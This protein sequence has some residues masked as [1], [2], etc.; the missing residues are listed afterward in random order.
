MRR[1]RGDEHGFGHALRA[2]ATHVAGNLPTAGGMSDEDDVGEVKVVDEFGEVVA[3]LVHVMT[4]PG[5]AGPAV[6]PAV[7][8]DHPITVTGQEEHLRVPVVGAE[9]GAVGEDNRLAG[10]PV[11]VEDFRAVLDGNL[12]GKNS[13]WSAID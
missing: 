12:G 9:W 7:V 2:V 11:F 3:V 10:A 8:R 6:A 4:A 1:H 5:L 13:Y